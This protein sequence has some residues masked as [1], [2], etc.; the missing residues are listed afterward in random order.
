ML[1]IPDRLHLIRV[2]SS[3]TVP[4]LRL[5]PEALAEVRQ[6]G[7]EIRQG[8]APL[9]AMEKY[10][11]I[12]KMLKKDNADALLYETSG[13]RSAEIIPFP[14]NTEPPPLLKKVQQAGKVDGRLQRIGGSKDWVPIHLKTL[15]GA[16][17]SR[18]YAKRALAKD[19]GKHLFEPVRLYGRGNWSLSAVGH[20]TMESFYVDTFDRLSNKSLLEVVSALRSVKA[21]WSPN[22]VA[23][24][25]GEANKP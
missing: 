14:G 15:D 5:D 9:P 11:N 21:D 17:I 7:A 2:E 22:P 10:R 25:L 4:V 6:R 18:C 3:S 8:I 23:S 12:N 1:G 20:W 13:G 19:I 24:I 16:A